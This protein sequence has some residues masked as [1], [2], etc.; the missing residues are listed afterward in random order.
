M[1]H[2]IRVPRVCMYTLYIYRCL[3]HCIHVMHYT[4]ITY[5]II[6]SYKHIYIY[7]CNVGTKYYLFHFFF[8]DIRPKRKELSSA[9]QYETRA[10][11]LAIRLRKRRNTGTGLVQYNI[12]VSCSGKWYNL[13]TA[14][15][16]QAVWLTAT[17]QRFC[18]ITATL[19]T[20]SFARLQ[21]FYANCWYI[22]YRKLL[23]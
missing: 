12:M 6:A 10:R 11:A 23:L 21:V 3:I 22:F 20:V 2:A 4:N 15:I 13:I 19:R 1:Q 17:G 7:T 8:S 16:R 5:T 14:S 18:P 9:R